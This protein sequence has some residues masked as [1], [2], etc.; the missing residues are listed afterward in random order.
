[1]TL[2]LLFQVYFLRL[3]V[4]PYITVIVIALLALGS[5]R[6][7]WYS[8][9][10]AGLLVGTL[11]MPV[12]LPEVGAWGALG[13]GL[14]LG[15]ALGRLSQVATRPL[16]IASSAIGAGVGALSVCRML[17]LGSPWDVVALAVGAGLGAGLAWRLPNRASSLAIA[18]TAA[19]A[20]GSTIGSWLII[21]KTAGGWAELAIMVV[22][23]I[24][25]LVRQ[26]VDVPVGRSA[27]G[28][29]DGLRPGRSG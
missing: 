25:G 15:S 7:P 22:V 23:L 28:T 21:L 14:V 20:V 5:S 29:S 13:V 9:L 24:V 19:A 11:A 12:L 2:W 18:L 16:L 8:S 3:E 1:M 4:W 26:P 6:R 17:G 10:L 27:T